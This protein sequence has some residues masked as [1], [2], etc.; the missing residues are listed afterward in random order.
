MLGTLSRLQIVTGNALPVN[1]PAW[2]DPV[3]RSRDRE[4]RS[5][6]SDRAKR[7][8]PA[9]ERDEGG[10]RFA[11]HEGV[12]DDDH[13]ERKAG[14]D[15]E[16]QRGVGER[17]IE[18]N[19]PDG[20]RHTESGRRG[21]EA[22]SQDPDPDTGPS[23]PAATQRAAC[24]RVLPDERE[25][26]GHAGDAMRDVQDPGRGIREEPGHDARREERRDRR[27]QGEVR[28]AARHRSDAS[29]RPLAD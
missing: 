28:E 9:R 5:Q 12:S 19:E 24:D 11:P 4:R 26:E 8:A 23:N 7:G 10:P 2:R 6:E 3:E 14:N 25:D 17:P 15:V 20:P 16:V 18:R 13:R 22:R 1:E 27:E 21:R 29:P